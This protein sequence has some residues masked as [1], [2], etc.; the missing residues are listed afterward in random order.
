[1]PQRHRRAARLLEAV[2]LPGNATAGTADDWPVL[3]PFRD[4]VVHK[5]SWVPTAAVTGAATNNFALE[6][7]NR[8][9]D[10]AGTT[11]LGIVTFGSGTNAAA[12]DATDVVTND[13]VVG[14]NAVVE[15]RKV[16]NGT[17][18]AMPDGLLVIEYSHQYETY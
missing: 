5:V 1:M 17:G 3:L 8:G 11:S 18:M 10:G 13:K 2:H 9:T 6:I 4:A 15:A 12:Y 14:A 16:V 7:R